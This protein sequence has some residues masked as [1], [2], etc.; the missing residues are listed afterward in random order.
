[1]PRPAIIAREQKFKSTTLRR[2]QSHALY[3]IINP[4]LLGRPAKIPY[5]ENTVIRDPPRLFFGILAKR[6]YKKDLALTATIIRF[7]A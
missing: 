4:I 3:Q 2:E 1:M 5:P 7:E 6:G